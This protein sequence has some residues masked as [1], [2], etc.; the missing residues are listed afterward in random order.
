MRSTL[1]AQSVL[2]LV[3]AAGLA[4]SGSVAANAAA[5][6]G[7]CTKLNSTTI[8]GSKILKCTK[9]GSKKVWVSAGIAYGTSGAPAPIGKA[10]KIGSGN[11]TL[12]SV[13]EGIDEWI[14][15]ENSFN[16]GCTWDDDF[17]VIV[18]PTST[19]KWVRFNFDVS[20]AGS[21]IL[22]PYFGD[23]GVVSKGKISWQGW[24][25]PTVD[26]AVDDLT[27]LSGSMDSGALYVQV[28]KSLSYTQL[29]LRPNLFENSFYF[30]NTN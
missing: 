22:E 25:Q 20:N 27:I 28:P 13:E 7:T 4:F 15:E 3:L 18:D 6:G 8:S 12:T 29:V 2:A 30:F 17:E 11:Y 5:A 21:G 1:K 16:N 24:L 9:K 19:K 23:V 14:C 26:G 10:I